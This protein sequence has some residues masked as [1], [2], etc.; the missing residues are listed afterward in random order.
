MGESKCEVALR[1]FTKLALLLG[2]ITYI[3]V[4]DLET[5]YFV[6]NLRVMTCLG[7]S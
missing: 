4:G 7:T 1:S 2:P 3:R 6:L 5:D